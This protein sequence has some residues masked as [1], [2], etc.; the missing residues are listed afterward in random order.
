MKRLKFI[1]CSGVNEHITDVGKLFVLAEKYP[2]IEFGIQVSGK[3]CS[4][5]SERF[6]WL[7]EIRRY[8]SVNRL[9]INMALH[10]NQ[11]WVE[12]LCQ[13][14]IVSEL[15]DLLNM[16]TFNM[17][18]LFKRI[19]LNFRIGREKSP[20]FDEL[21]QILS[22][23]SISGRR[24]ILSYNY[25]NAQIINELYEEGLRFDCLYDASFGEGIIPNSR[26]APAFADLNIL[27]GY[28]GGISPENVKGELNKIADVMPTEREFFI[29]AEGKLK[30]SNG[31]VSLK[32]CEQYVINALEWQ[33]SL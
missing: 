27:Q 32:K 25:F 1:T 11:D 19:Q 16:R 22:S 9:P 23:Y 4:F 15:V 20:N 31:I 30:N 10:I 28:A 3:K 12:E 8:S 29:D 24:F 2:Q 14:R 21:Y 26:E 18:L 6:Q 13:G 33:K 17:Q 5:D 7:R